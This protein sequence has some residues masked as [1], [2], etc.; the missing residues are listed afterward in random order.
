MMTTTRALSVKTT[1]RLALKVRNIDTSTPAAATSAPPS[2]KASAEAVRTSMATSWAATGSTATARTAVPMR[3]RV[4][5][6]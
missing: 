6:K 4:R 1:P 3:V 2:A 5:P